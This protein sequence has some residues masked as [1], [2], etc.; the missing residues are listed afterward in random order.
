[1]FLPLLE[2]S[3]IRNGASLLGMIVQV[4]TS[5]DLVSTYEITRVKRHVTTFAGAFEATTEQLWLQTSEGL[6]ER[7][8]SSSS[9][10]SES[11]ANPRSAQLPPSDAASQSLRI[12]A[13][14]LRAIGYLLTLVQ[15]ASTRCQR[16]GRGHY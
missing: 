1:M 8:A 6:M 3:K 15:V 10:P 7:R 11:A 14:D 5:D 13:T 12:L 2:R 16:E 9:W 4:W